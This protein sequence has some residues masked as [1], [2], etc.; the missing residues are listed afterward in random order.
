MPRNIFGFNTIA[1]RKIA[2]PTEIGYFS[3][4]R[5]GLLRDCAV[6]RSGAGVLILQGD[7]ASDDCSWD[8]RIYPAYFGDRYRG[9]T[10]KDSEC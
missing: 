5:R 6:Y 3:T 2:F 9:R 7:C 8:S 1:E 10:G 4:F